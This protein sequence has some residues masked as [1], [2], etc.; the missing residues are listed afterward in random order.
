MW[1]TTSCP[2]SRPKSHPS[3][4][5]VPVNH[6]GGFQSFWTLLRYGRMD[7]S[8]IF[9]KGRH[10][11]PGLFWL[12]RASGDVPRRRCGGRS[13]L[14]SS[15]GGPECRRGGRTTG[16][17]RS[18]EGLRQEVNGRRRGELEGLTE[19]LG[20]DSTKGL[21]HRSGSF[22]NE[23]I[24]RVDPGSSRSLCRDSLKKFSSSYFRT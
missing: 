9:K 5:W 17:P 7:D 20:E 24:P 13:V 10:F 8:S 19:R 1:V 11:G 6:F 3:Q 2:W 14:V 21:R 23:Q 16:S 15:P 12:S 22:C 4:P 18:G